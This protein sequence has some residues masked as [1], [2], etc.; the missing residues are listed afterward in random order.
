MQGLN[1]Y[2][3]I[4]DGMESVNVMA[5][6]SHGGGGV[7]SIKSH[8]RRI[9]SEPTDSLVGLF[10]FTNSGLKILLFNLFFV[11]IYIYIYI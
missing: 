8:R 1:V 11:Y 4:R 2:I 10:Y 9:V 5:K 3:I 7:G 6:I